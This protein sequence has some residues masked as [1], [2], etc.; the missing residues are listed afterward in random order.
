MIERLLS[1]MFFVC[2]L[3][4]RTGGHSNRILGF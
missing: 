4:V 3:K 2:L 1:L